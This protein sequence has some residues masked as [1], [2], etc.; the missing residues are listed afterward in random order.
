MKQ[1][2]LRRWFL[3]ALAAG[4]LLGAL[5][6]DWLRPAV[7]LLP[8]RAVVSLALFFMA[9]A[10]ESRSLGRSLLRPLPALWASAIS[11]TLVPLLAW[12]FARWLPVALDFRAGLVIMAA[13]PCT[14]A[15]AV[16]WTRLGGGN[17]AVALLTVVLTTATSWLITPLWLAPLG[18]AVSLNTQDMMRDLLL[19]MVLPV[20]AGQL[21]RAVPA[22]AAL[23]TRRKAVLGVV[24]QLLILAILLKAATEVGDRLRTNRADYDL[25]SVLVIAAAGIVTHLAAL[26]VGLGSSRLLGF[27]RPSQIAVAFACSQKTLPVALLVFTDFFREKY[28]LAVLPIVL[29]HFSQLLVDTVI[30]DRLRVSA[31]TGKEAKPPP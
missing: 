17:E 19:Y 12:G 24:S 4:A 28:P 8:P 2:L 16:I 21:A 3:L 5:V 10:L 27:D 13:V 22:L 18:R 31:P 25:V 14:L 9:W 15:S 26:G 23:A 6:P 11:Y 7:E 29:Y 1:F 20:A 30:A